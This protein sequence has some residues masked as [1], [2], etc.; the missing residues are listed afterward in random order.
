MYVSRA[1]QCD[2]ADGAAAVAAAM[3]PPGQIATLIL[4]ADTA[5]GP[6][7]GPAKPIAAPRRAAPTS[8]EIKAAAAALRSGEPCA[9]LMNGAALSERG[10]ELASRIAQ[11]TGAQ[12]FADTFV[13]RIARGAGRVDVQRVPYFGEQAA[14]VLAPYR[15]LIFVATK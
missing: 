11:R 8:E 9:L 2:A 1:R 3:T 10:L 15:H 5:W 4:P 14:E 13:T 12:L 6:A 7:S